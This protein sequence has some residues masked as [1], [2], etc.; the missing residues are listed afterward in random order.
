MNVTIFG[1][2]SYIGRYLMN[3]FA[4]NNHSVIAFVNKPGQI[5]LPPTN[6]RIM[7][8]HN[9]DNSLVKN[10]ISNSDIVINAYKPTIKFFKDKR[11]YINRISNKTIIE[12]ME[13]LDKKRFITISRLM[14]VKH[15]QHKS[16]F[17]SVLINKLLYKNYKKEFLNTEKLLKDSNLDWTILKIIH[18][19]SSNKK[20]IFRYNDGD[21]K[22]IHRFLSDYN[23]ACFLYKIATE[24]LFVKDIAIASNK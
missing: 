2:E 10:A 23:A 14:N 1:A 19:A 18:T 15:N 8:G 4:I 21:N 16:F 13:K 20:G 9:N 11:Y 3:L 12:E 7:V 5:R 17:T 6:V 24:D 22:K